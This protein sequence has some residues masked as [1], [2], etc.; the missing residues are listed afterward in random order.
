MVTV[1]PRPSLCSH[2]Y[3]ARYEREGKLPVVERLVEP[4]TEFSHDLKKQIGYL[5]GL[6]HRQHDFT[7]ML[8]ALKI[9]LRGAGF[10]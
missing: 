1:D 3:H 9:M 5:N 8:A 10:G 2:F 7:K 4:S 6:L